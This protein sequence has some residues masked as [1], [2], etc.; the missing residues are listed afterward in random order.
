MTSAKSFDFLSELKATLSKLT[1]RDEPAAVEDVTDSVAQT[2]T[3]TP[4]LAITQHVDNGRHNQQNHQAGQLETDRQTGGTCQRNVLY[5]ELS[6]VLEKRGHQHQRLSEEQTTSRVVELESKLKPGKSIVYLGSGQRKDGVPVTQR[7]SVAEPRAP[8]SD[9]I[10]TSPL[11][12]E[13]NTATGGDVERVDG[14]EEDSNSATD[15]TSTSSAVVSISQVCASSNHGNQDSACVMSADESADSS[16]CSLLTAEHEHEHEHQQ[17]PQPQPQPQR[18][19]TGKSRETVVD[20]VSEQHQLTTSSDDDERRRQQRQHFATFPLIRRTPPLICRNAPA[21][22]VDD[23]L[24]HC[25]RHDDV[26]TT[27]MI[28][29]S[30]EP[31]SVGLCHQDNVV[32]DRPLSVPVTV[33]EPTSFH[34][35]GSQIRQ[36]LLDHHRSS[37]AQRPQHDKTSTRQEF[38]RRCRRARRR[39]HRRRTGLHPTVVDST[40]SDSEMTSQPLSSR[41]WRLSPSPVFHLLHHHH[42]AT[43]CVNSHKDAQRLQ[44]NSPNSLLIDSS[45][46]TDSQSFCQVHTLA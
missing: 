11:S 24:V 20:L 25:Q 4:K 31:I 22:V 34:K 13:V 3:Q 42:Q 44:L 30:G 14:G 40:T 46:D 41:N 35:D 5:G 29:H 36:Q 9:A 28:T 6:S 18:G 23:A 32:V 8:C 2:Q 27:L 38:E 15:V 37:S 26:I 19:E 21:V 12:D 39:R 33:P 45:A 43:Y 1:A 16:D 10:V 7:V 17:Q